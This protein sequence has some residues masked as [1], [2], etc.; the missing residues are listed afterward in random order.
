MARKPSSPDPLDT[1]AVGVAADHAAQKAG[2]KAGAEATAAG[3]T[4]EESTALATV[5]EEAV[6]DATATDD[7]PADDS[8]PETAFDRR[9][10]R[11]VR[12]VDE[13]EFSSGTARGDT[14]DVLIELFK[15]RDKPWHML[16]ANERRDLAVHLDKIAQGIVRKIV[17]V[18]AEEDS[19]ALQGTMLDK[20]A[21]TGE[22]LEVK[23]KV[24]HVDKDVLLAAYNL[25]GSRVVI[26]SA[27]DKRF[28]AERRPGPQ[29]ERQIDIPFADAAPSAEKPEAPADDSDLADG[30]DDETDPEGSSFALYDEGADVWLSDGDGDDTWTEDGD[31]AKRHTHAEALAA[32]EEFGGGDELHVKVHTLDT[33]EPDAG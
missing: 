29:G 1:L 13:A 26:V 6:A 27:D 4:E 11:L 14:R 31:K 17:L 23:L 21:V 12:I 2:A 24:E 20:I 16:D 5:V 28:S 18:V 32:K 19:P 10:A 9:I 22:A 33:A 7:P 25:A 3:S 15:A 30:A 8:D